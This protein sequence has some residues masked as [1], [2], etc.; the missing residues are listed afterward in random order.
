[1][2]LEGCAAKDGVLCEAQGAVDTPQPG[3]VCSVRPAAAGTSPTPSW[4]W[5][6]FE[7]QE[8][9]LRLAVGVT[10]G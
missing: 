8:R 7:A 6:A 5:V 9:G 2:H 1:M 10:H 4:E 3:D